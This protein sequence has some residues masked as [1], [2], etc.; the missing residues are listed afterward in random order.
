MAKQIQDG[1]TLDI[2]GEKKRG[3]PVT[4]NALSAAERAKRYRE[5]KSIDEIVNA[6]RINFLVKKFSVEELK[7]ELSLT[8]DE[9]LA[10]D[11]WK[12]MGVKMGWI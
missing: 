5:K 12:A 10:K 6:E 7:K 1:R 4:G 2:F 8:G 3:R 9:D 11:Y